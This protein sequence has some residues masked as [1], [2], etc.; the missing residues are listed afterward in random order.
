M[1]RPPGELWEL[2]ERPAHPLPRSPAPSRQAAMCGGH[3]T[4]A[5]RGKTARGWF[6]NYHDLLLLS[7]TDRAVGE[8]TINHRYLCC[9]KSQGSIFEDHHSHALQMVITYVKVAQAGKSRE[10]HRREDLASQGTFKPCEDGGTTLAI[11]P[12]QYVSWFS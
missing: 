4:I 3:V 5:W 10:L 8:A 1:L 2:H 7:I 12:P 9:N 6:H 11:C